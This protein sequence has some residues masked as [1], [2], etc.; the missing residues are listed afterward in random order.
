MASCLMSWCNLLAPEHLAFG[1]ALDL[2][3]ICCAQKMLGHACLMF[4][5]LSLQ[6][7]MHKRPVCRE[8]AGL[9]HTMGWLGSIALD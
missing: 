7:H 3:S 2:V 4:I 6:Q 1:A 5:G 9:W 8:K